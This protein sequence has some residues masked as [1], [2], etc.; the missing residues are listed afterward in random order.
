MSEQVALFERGKAAKVE[1]TV[2]G[3][4]DV[5]KF[6]EN[7]EGLAEAAGGL[8]KLRGL[9][10]DLAVRG[11]LIRQSPADKSV[12]E[13]LSKFASITKDAHLEEG[14]FALPASWEWAMIGRVCSYIQRGKSPRY[15]ESSSVPVVSQK[16][17]QW[18]GFLIDRA[19][20]IDPDS[21]VGY[22]PERFLREGDLLWNSTGHGTVG[23]VAVFT[24]HPRFKQVVADSHVTVLRPFVEPRYLWCWLSSPTVQATIDDLVSGTTKQTELATST[25]VAHPVPVPPMD[26]QK[27]IVAK[28][29]QLMALCDELEARQTKKRETGARLTKSA[30]EALTSAEG[31]EELDAAWGR[32][33]ENFD[34]LVERADAVNDMRRLVLDLVCGGRF[35]RLPSTVRSGAAT[36]EQVA[37]ERTRLE[38]L[39]IFRSEA[40]DLAQWDSSRPWPSIPLVFLL[41]RPLSNGRSVPDG[42]GFPV[43]RLSAFRG[44]F[45]DPMECKKGA[46]TASDAEPFVAEHG[47][48]LIVRGNGAI[49]LVGRACIVGDGMPPIAFPDTAIRARLNPTL[50]DTDWFWYF[51][52]SSRARAQIEARAKTTAGIFKVSQ[53]DLYAVVV[54]V[55]PLDEQKNLVAFIDRIMHLCDELE[56]RLRRAEDR[57]AKLVAAV[58]QELV[59]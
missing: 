27:R 17:V 58:V 59:A 40:M 18:E 28:V 15:V 35:S 34:V 1:E 2:G 52:E 4:F 36:I 10:L 48:L 24:P 21:L 8:Q 51:W 49:R 33:V 31:P 39:G 22:A 9:V 26:E 55:P 7:F 14:P 45:V 3:G 13:Q 25:V 56:A 44:R 29:D 19:R 57:A 53:E 32:V 30:L 11:R 47:D 43:L 37:S 46:W 23:R 54:P 16:C 42:G 12:S 38:K 5:Q 50:I 6:V 20:F 41:A